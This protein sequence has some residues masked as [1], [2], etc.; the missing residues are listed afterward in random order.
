MSITYGVGCHTPG[1]GESPL[2]PLRWLREILHE[3]MA[4]DRMKVPTDPLVGLQLDRSF[5]KFHFLKQDEEQVVLYL[6]Y[7]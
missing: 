6:Y 7:C 2:I 4:E 1:V 3:E 5:L